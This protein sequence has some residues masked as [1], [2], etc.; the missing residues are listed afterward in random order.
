MP[1]PIPPAGFADRF[2]QPAVIKNS[3]PIPARRVYPEQK[4]AQ[5]NIFNFI[6]MLYNRQ[7][8][9]GGARTPPTG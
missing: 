2:R 9:P 5:G 8:K 3:P 1:L 7:R 4:M 6:E